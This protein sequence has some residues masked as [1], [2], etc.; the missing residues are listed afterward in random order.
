MIRNKTL[1]AGLG[2]GVFSLVYLWEARGLPIGSTAQ[3]G[4][5]YVPDLIGKIALFLSVVV[6]I[7]SWLAERREGSRI[8]TPIFD[9]GKSPWILGVLVIVYPLVLD[10]FGFFLATVPFLYSSL[11]VMGHRGKLSAI[12]ISLSMVSISYYLF[13]MVMSVRFPAGFFG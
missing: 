1:V 8:S 6:V 7:R 10:S 3:P 4:I 5:G 11:W 13:A 12:V 9:R 2:C